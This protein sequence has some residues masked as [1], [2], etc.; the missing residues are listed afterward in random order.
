M[1]YSILSLLIIPVIYSDAEPV[2]D[3][4]GRFSETYDSIHGISDSKFLLRNST[5]IT[6]FDVKTEQTI[7]TAPCTGFLRVNVNS[8]VA[9]CSEATYN[10]EIL[11]FSILNQG[12]INRFATPISNLTVTFNGNGHNNDPNCLRGSGGS[13]N[14]YNGSLL[15]NQVDLIHPTHRQWSRIKLLNVLESMMID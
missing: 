2:L 11:G 1:K 3:K 12:P 7:D 15:V 10:I 13:V 4:E 6:L 14:I 8:T 9:M 5:S